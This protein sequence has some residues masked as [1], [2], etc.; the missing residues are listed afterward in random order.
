ML[1]IVFRFGYLALP[2]AFQQIASLSRIANASHCLPLRL[3][4]FTQSLSTNRFAFTDS[5]CFALSSAS[6]ISLYPKPLQQQTSFAVV[7]FLC[8]LAYKSTLLTLLA[9]K[10]PLTFV[11]GFVSRSRADS[12]RCGSFCRALPSHSA[13][14]PSIG[15]RK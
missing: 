15:T 12:N 11:R 14:G 7:L 13:T 3:S 1:R 6:A 5:Q 8:S 9:L 2:K 10:K 4:R